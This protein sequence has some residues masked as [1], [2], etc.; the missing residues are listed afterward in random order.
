M[1]PREKGR[2]RAPTN[3]S[4]VLMN[5][6]PM[7]SAIEEQVQHCLQCL[8]ELLGAELLGV[9]LYGSSIVGG[10]QRYSD[11]DLFAVSGR[12]LTLK[13]KAILEGRLLSISGLYRST[14]RRPIELTIVVKSEVNPWRY[15]PSFDFQYGEWL[16]D[17]FEAGRV[18]PWPEGAKPDLALMITQIHLASRTLRGGEPDR[19]LP[20]VPYKDFITALAEELDGL[21]KEVSSDTRNVLLTLARIW[22]TAATDSIS[23]KQ[24]AAEWAGQE[25]PENYKTIMLRALTAARGEQEEVWSDVSDSIPACADF[26][27]D[28]IRCRLERIE[29]SANISKKISLVW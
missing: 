18:E 28:E 14:E 11:V 12:P 9:Y 24:K 25:L 17:E 8:D 29:A 10:L 21:R 20:H 3:R 6:F 19:L 7:D 23:S 22:R 5:A 26:M 27:I 4:V 1:L 16:R 13:E 15:P 2:Q